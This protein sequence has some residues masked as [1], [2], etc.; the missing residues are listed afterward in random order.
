[1]CRV[2]EESTYR[3]LVEKSQE[4]RPFGRPRHRCKKNIKIYRNGIGYEKV[5]RIGRDQ[6]TD[7]QRDVCEAGDK[8]SA[9]GS[10]LI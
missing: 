8:L 10:S 4:R 2:W 5:D 7:N 1:M 9:S 3:D 6:G